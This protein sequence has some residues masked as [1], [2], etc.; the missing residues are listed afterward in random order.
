MKDELRSLF[1]PHPSDFIFHKELT[2]PRFLSILVPFGLLTIWLFASHGNEPQK[3]DEPKKGR[4]LLMQKKLDHAQK[5]LEGVAVQ[6]YDL[7]ER[8]ADEL[9]LISKKAE[10]KVIQT[11]DYVRH[12]EDFRRNGELLV[13]HAK[14]KNIDAAALAYVQ[15]TLSCVNCHKHVR[16]VRIASTGD[17]AGTIGE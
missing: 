17:R 13:K 10:W 4:N 11:P 15:M 2:M 8:N 7:I 12:S 9:I 5:V 6:D 14:A 16:E 3:K 1:R